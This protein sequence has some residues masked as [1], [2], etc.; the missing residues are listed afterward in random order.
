MIFQAALSLVI[1]IFFYCGYIKEPIKLEG[2]APDN[3]WTR[4]LI[5]L[6]PEYKY[7][8]FL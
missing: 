4:K 7:N 2:E 1:Y 5:G 8:F 3:W 6:V